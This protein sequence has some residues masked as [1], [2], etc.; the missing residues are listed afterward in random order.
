M[1]AR[2]HQGVF[3]AVLI[4]VMVA[5]Y[6][7][8]LRPST[9]RSPAGSS[10]SGQEASS[11]APEAGEAGSS[12]SS[13]EAVRVVQVLPDQAPRRKVQRERAA[14]LVWRADPFNRSAS[15]DQVGELTLSGIL[16]DASAPIAILNG[17][18]TR[19]GDEVDGY[20]VTEIAPDRVSVTD[21]TRTLTLRM[22]P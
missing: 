14:G 9:P 8:A 2:R 16:W 1:M 13:P 7:R 20:R 12:S 15:G 21:G 4:G 17:Q 11:G 6:A 3:L 5:V 19:V 10:D 22:T 18:M